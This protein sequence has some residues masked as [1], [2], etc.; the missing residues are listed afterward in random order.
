MSQKPEP[1]PTT[2]VERYLARDEHGSG[3]I[4]D[5]VLLLEGK[6][7]V[8][9]LANAWQET[10]DENPQFYY[11]LA[12]R[13]TNQI[14][15][16]T[17][18]QSDLFTVEENGN[19]EI[20][21]RRGV[22]ARLSVARSCDA[23]IDHADSTNVSDL[24]LR[25]SFHHVA[26]DGVGA[27]RVIYRTMQRYRDGKLPPRV[28]VASDEI[29]SSSSSK[30]ASKGATAKSVRPQLSNFWATIRGHNAR[31]SKHAIDQSTVNT[32]T[33][34]AE[35][36]PPVF[37]ELSADRSDKIRSR[38]RERSIPVNDFGI[39]MTLHAL[40]ATTRPGRGRYLSIMNPV[41]MRKWNQRYS[42]RNQIGFAFV[43][44]RHDQL[45]SINETLD[46]IS[47]QMKYVRSN[48]IAGE[49]AQGIEIAERIPGGLTCIDRLG[50]FVPT[51]SVTCLSG[52]K[53]GKRAGLSSTPKVS[54]LVK[55]S[56][57][58]QDA[59]T[60]RAG[61]AIVKGLRISGPLQSRG[62]LSITI[63]DTGTGLNLSLRGPT[64]KD[65][66]GLESGIA[67]EIELVVDTFLSE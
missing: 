55:S 64:Q 29:P 33:L 67:K 26:C 34:L 66:I 18:F 27:A 13:G 5:V 19:S 50:W 36:L 1:I 2:A 38:L 31:L 65:M 45:S 58:I 17:A 46:S 43:R 57:P 14:W 52:L 32:S 7:D 4:F 60:Y 23:S 41:Q 44:R 20:N 39:A 42:T 25:F 37:L 21:V 30:G 28:S 10:I 6:C 62:Q 54:S 47:A 8:D 51:A 61:D 11:Q 3:M 24:Q 56:Q 63:W 16:P 12:G 9:R 48:G 40:A 15:T 53:F 59:Q 49:L 22:G 35:D